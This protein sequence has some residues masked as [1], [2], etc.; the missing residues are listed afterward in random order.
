[1]RSKVGISLTAWKTF[2]SSWFD[3]ELSRR[4]ERDSDSK[5]SAIE[6]L[7]IERER[8]HFLDEDVERFRNTGLERVFAAD[9]RFVDLGAARDVVGLHR[10]NFL[11]RVGGAVRLERPDLHFA[12]TLAAELGLAAQRLLRDERV[13]TD[14]TR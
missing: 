4:C 10:E 1:M 11:Q 6:Q 14:R 9:D 8:T 13:R 3:R 7:H 12:E 5:V 2:I